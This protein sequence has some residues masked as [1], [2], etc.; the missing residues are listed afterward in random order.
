[1]L[2]EDYII[3]PLK[4]DSLEEICSFNASVTNNTLD[5]NRQRD[6]LTKIVTGPDKVCDLTSNGK[7]IGVGV[8]I[9]GCE[10]SSNSAELSILVPGSN[11]SAMDAVL[12]WAAPV[13]QKSERTTIDLPEW[14]GLKFPSDWILRN[15]FKVGYYMCEMEYD[16]KVEQP[17]PIPTPS[18]W[19]WDTHNEKYFKSYYEVLR[20][21]FKEIPG[22]FIPEESVSRERSETQSPKVELLLQG[23][24]VVG[25]VRVQMKS[26]D[27][28]ELA[29]LGRHPKFRGHGV[30]SHLVN[31]GLDTLKKL[32]ATKILL[33][34]AATNNQALSLYEK[35][36]FVLNKKMVVYQKKK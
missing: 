32:G 35:S 10:N 2:T 22:C 21:S 33:E 9:D 23:D 24:A 26:T 28:G 6:V 4:S 11:V 7:R 27:E 3:R 1:M 13:I 20:E 5:K 8:L 34:V 14:N 36:G 18:K 12:N 16:P 25:F 31:R 19:K 15:G 30:G 29:I 17:S